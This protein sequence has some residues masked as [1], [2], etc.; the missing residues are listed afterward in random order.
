[1]KSTKTYFK[2]KH[3]KNFKKKGKK[4]SNTLWITIVIHDAMSVG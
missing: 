1:M 3:N 2:K 4:K